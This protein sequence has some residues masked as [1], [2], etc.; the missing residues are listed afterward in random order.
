[1]IKVSVITPIYNRENW[2]E[3]LVKNLKAQTLNEIEFIIIDDGSN[4][5]T[6]E[7]IRKQ[8]QQDKR[9]VLIK[10]LKN[11][12]PYHARNIGLE[13]AQGE[14]IGF[15]DSDDNIPEDYFQS[16][17]EQAIPKQADIVYTSYNNL[18]HLLK[19]ITTEIDKIRVLKNGAIWDK[20]F[21][22]KYLNKKQIKFTEG[23]YTADNLFIIQAFL[24]TNNIVL[25]ATPSY[26]YKIQK[27]SIGKDSKKQAK[28]KQDIMIVLDRALKMAGQY[29]KDQS[30]QEEFLL[31]LERS[32]FD[33]KKDK[34]FQEQFY[35]K[36]GLERSEKSKKT[37]WLKIL[38]IF[39]ILRIIS[40]K[41]YQQERQI[42]IVKSSDL[43]DEKWYEKEY[44]ISKNAAKDYV[45][46]GWKKGRNPS[47]N[48]DGNQ[49]LK[50]YPEVKELC[51]LVHYLTQ[52]RKEGRRYY[53]L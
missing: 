5:K 31:F 27:D 9:F 48:F 21:K 45:K 3:N 52:G 33:Y 24:Q 50:D 47:L 12:G 22:R 53:P 14:Y 40:P 1:M 43:F 37:L 6:Y 29:I 25:T 38:K 26:E 4:D 35:K 44:Q 8:T 13:K 17:Y 30:M 2:V 39:K 10:S 20:L 34:K 18:S 49:Y 51:P 41:K 42:E 7:K 16:L 15:F 46:T 32:L 28:R 11:L 23:L 19:Q 36:L